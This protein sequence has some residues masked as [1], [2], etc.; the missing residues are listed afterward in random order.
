MSVDP[1][2]AKIGKAY[3]DFLEKASANSRLSELAY[4]RA[5]DL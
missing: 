5:R 1:A 4:L 2:S 3:F